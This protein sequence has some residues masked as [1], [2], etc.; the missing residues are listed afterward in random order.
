MQ[1]QF[2]T[3]FLPPEFLLLCP[4]VRQPP[5]LLQSELLVSLLHLTV[6]QHP[7]LLQLL[8]L[9]AELAHAEVHPPEPEV[10]QLAAGPDI[11]QIKL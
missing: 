3:F 10:P 1:G 5:V 6:Q 8:P 2:V 11:H 4:D 9:P 7:H